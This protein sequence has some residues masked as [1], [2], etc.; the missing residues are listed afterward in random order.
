MCKHWPLEHSAQA[1][2][3]WDGGANLSDADA[4]LGS[5]ETFARALLSVSTVLSQGRWHAVGRGWLHPI[6]YCLL[7]TS[8]QCL[9][10]W[11]P[12]ITVSLRSTGLVS[13]QFLVGWDFPFF[14][15]FLGRVLKDSFNNSLTALLFANVVVAALLRAFSLLR[16]LRRAESDV[17]MNTLTR[18]VGGLLLPTVAW[19]WCFFWYP[20]LQFLI[21]SLENRG[22]LQ[23]WHWWPC[24]WRWCAPRYGGGLEGKQIPC[25]H[26]FE[27]NI[28]SYMM[29]FYHLSFF[30]VVK[31]GVLWVSRFSKS[32]RSETEENSVWSTQCIP[33]NF[34]ESFV[35]FVGY[36]FMLLSVFVIVT[37][38]ELQA[39]IRGFLGR[40]EFKEVLREQFVDYL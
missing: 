14:Y 32:F 6:W 38:P 33:R 11:K 17:F 24:T 18:K 16:D 35:S 3:A 39:I 37:I 10:K 29:V 28:S 9:V 23:R 1:G 34:Q 19:L 27:P 15:S 4:K 7:T 31:T 13:T 20:R 30:L 12:P 5:F 2:P 25:Y 40:V 26:L 8:R 22:T 21:F 36:Y